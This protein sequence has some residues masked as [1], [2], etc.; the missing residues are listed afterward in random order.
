MDFKLGE[1]TYNKENKKY[2]YT[3]QLIKISFIWLYFPCF[4]HISYVFSL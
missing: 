2:S 4:L 3:A 1:G